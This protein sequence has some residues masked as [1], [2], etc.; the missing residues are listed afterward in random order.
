[1]GALIL[2]G[3]GGEESGKEKNPER[4]RGF[5]GYYLSLMQLWL[6]PKSPLN[7]VNTFKQKAFAPFLH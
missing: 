2:L 1:M 6:A 5:G 4:K 3:W 7:T